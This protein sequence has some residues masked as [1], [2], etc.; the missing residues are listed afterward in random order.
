MF[1]KNPKIFTLYKI[2]N[3]RN[4]WGI[5]KMFMFSKSILTFKLCFLL[6]KN[7]EKYKIC[8]YFTKIL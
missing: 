4:V 6:S 3:T 2:T 7:V 8:S 5:R 1:Q